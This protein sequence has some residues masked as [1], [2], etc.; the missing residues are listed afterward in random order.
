MLHF[1][2]RISPL[3]PRPRIRLSRRARGSQRSVHVSPLL[4]STFTAGMYPLEAMAGHI[5]PVIFSWH[6]G[7]ELTPVAGKWTGAFP[8]QKFWMAWE[9]G[10]ETTGDPFAADWNFWVLTETALE[11]LKRRFRILPLGPG[12]AAADDG[13]EGFKPIE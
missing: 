3:V 12:E 2:R 10:A 13:R 6:L 9:R 4:V 5:L 1:Q 7:I 11:D 8:P